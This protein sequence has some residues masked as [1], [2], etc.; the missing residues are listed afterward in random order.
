MF[1]IL[2][3][4]QPLIDWLILVGESKCPMIIIPFTSLLCFTDCGGIF[5]IPSSLQ[6]IQLK[7]P[8]FPNHYQNSSSCTWT[9][10][11]QEDT[12]VYA[13]FYFIKLERKYDWLKVCNGKLCSA[14][15]QLAKLSGKI[16]CRIQTYHLLHHTHF[17]FWYF[18]YRQLRRDLM[19][20][21][22]LDQLPYTTVS[23]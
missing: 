15:S 14:N 18:M 5:V 22:F 20:L 13:Q 2:M 6:E 8:N 1:Y 10:Y 23:H 16:L 12:F 9:I 11:A 19:W 7:S 3:I 17:Y 4:L 21:Q